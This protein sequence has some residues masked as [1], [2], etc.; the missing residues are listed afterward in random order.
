MKKRMQQILR[1]SSL[2]LW[3]MVVLLLLA[4]S[5]LLAAILLEKPNSRPNLI[6]SRLNPIQLENQLPGTTDW[7]LS[8]SAP[9]DTKTFHYPAIE[10]YAWTTSAQA[11]DEVKF[12][13]STTSPS[14]SADVYRIG[15]YQGKGGRWV[16]SIPAIAGHTYPVPAPD[17][18]TGLIEANWPVAFT[19]KIDAHWVSGMYMVKLTASNGEQ[20]YIPFVLRSSRPSDF[21]FIHAVNTDEAYNL[22]GGISLYFNFT[23]IVKAKRAF[24]VSFD[25]PFEQDT[26]A[27]QFFRWEYPMVRWLEQQGYD[28]SYL[29]DLDLQNTSPLLQN[30]HA[31]LIVG[32]NEYWSKPMREALEMA[33]NKGVNLADFGANTLGWQIRYEPRNSG[34][35]PAPERI[36]VCYKDKALD[37]L[38]GKENSLV[39]EEFRNAPL[40]RPE[41][42]L[43]GAMYGSWWDPHQ[44][45]FPWVV[46]DASSWVF[47]GT[48]L[49]NGD[50][51]PGLVGYEYDKVYS[52]YPLPQGLQVLAA[53][54]VVD[55]FKHYDIANATLYTAAS[56]AR[57]FNAGT[58]EW[59]WGLDSNSSLWLR[60]SGSSSPA[61][62]YANLVNR[63]AQKITENILQN[64]LRTGSTPQDDALNLKGFT[65]YSIVILLLLYLVYCYWAWCQMSINVKIIR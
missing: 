57:V 7:Q 4:L 26:G 55:N 48:G 32:H 14:F 64:F 23:N 65:L 38:Y 50:S 56:G 59:S 27:G 37:P 19:L 28:L 49:R 62:T 39:T 2:G 20:S 47:A 18:G 29:S 3:G 21:A 52:N 13:V 54:P 22:W 31:L 43:L 11:G 61:V 42:V 36:L 46:A 40:Y 44:A 34:S 24:K 58:I 10:G 63:A 51:L 41:Q 1:A 45:G 17:A 5:I 30:Y 12:S 6:H 53:S 15:W 8:H 25:R 16:Q 35:Q 60:N 9:Y 33:I